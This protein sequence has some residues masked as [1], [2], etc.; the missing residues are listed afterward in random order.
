MKGGGYFTEGSE[1]SERHQAILELDEDD[2]HREYPFTK[3]LEFCM[4]K[5]MD[6]KA[7]DKVRADKRTPETSV[8][9]AHYFEDRGKHSKGDTHDYV[10]GDENGVIMPKLLLKKLQTVESGLVRPLNN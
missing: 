10:I 9:H 8:I 1:R 7:Q 4:T 6:A 5:T 3:D 2:L